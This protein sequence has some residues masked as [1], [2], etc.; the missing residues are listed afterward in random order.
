VNKVLLFTIQDATPVSAFKKEGDSP[1][2]KQNN[3][4]MALSTENESAFS[5]FEPT[6][7]QT[8]LFIDRFFHKLSISDL[9]IKYEMTPQKVHEYYA[10]AKRRV[11]DVLETL[12]SNRPLKLDHYWKKIEERS[13]SLPK[14]Q[15][16]FLMSKVFKLT[17]SQIAEIEGASADS[18]S[19]LISRVSDQLRAGKIEL[20]PVSQ[21]ESLEAKARLDRVRER[22]REH[23]QQNLEK[24]RAYDRN[25]NRK[26][27]ISK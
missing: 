3:L 18:V 11:F 19:V 27:T 8:I 22:R 16:W 14:G 4:E 5:S 13:G 20:F 26:K 15:R 6:L 1:K 2:N 23:R 24:M 12:D 17:P 25:R 9:S 10:Q 7:K 21:L